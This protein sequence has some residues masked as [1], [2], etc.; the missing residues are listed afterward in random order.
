MSFNIIGKVIAAAGNASDIIGTVDNPLG[1]SYGSFDGTGGGGGII[2][3]FTNILRLI[4]VA[5]GIY[6]LVN[7]ILA[8]FQYMQAGGDSKAITAAWNRIWQTLLGLIIIVGSF[9]LAALFGFLFFNDA[10]FI[11]RPQIYGPGTAPVPTP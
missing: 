5:A 8:G 9:A 11:L 1:N 2:G 3:F 6:A 10:G 7:L 4:F